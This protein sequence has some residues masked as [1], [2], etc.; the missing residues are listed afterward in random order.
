[1][2][3]LTY[4][5]SC[6]GKEL[7]YMNMNLYTFLDT[8]IQSMLVIEGIGS[9]LLANAP[10]LEKIWWLERER[11]KM[12]CLAQVLK[13]SIELWLIRHARWCGYKIYWWSLVSNSL[14]PMP[15]HCDNQF[16]IYIT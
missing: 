10:L 13:L 5:K 11:N 1:M 7:V 2:R 8:L 12:L 9:L 4:I 14:D 3:V 15:M 16:A 6:P